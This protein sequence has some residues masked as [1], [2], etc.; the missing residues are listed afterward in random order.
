MKQFTLESWMIANGKA[1]QSF[2]S[3]KQAKHLTAIAS[4]HNRKIETE[5]MVVV[6]TSKEKVQAGKII[7]IT[8]IN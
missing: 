1:G 4:A 6:S 7:K 2:Y 5:Q 3:E 8:L